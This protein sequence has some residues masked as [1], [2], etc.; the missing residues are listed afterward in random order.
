MLLLLLKSEEKPGKKVS[1][2][3]RIE[4]QVKDIFFHTEEKKNLT[5]LPAEVSEKRR[6]YTN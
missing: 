5:C 3:V 6:D 4:Q 1:S 2:C